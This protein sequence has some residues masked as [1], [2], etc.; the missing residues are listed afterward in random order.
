MRGWGGGREGREPREEEGEGR[1]RRGARRPW[2]VFYPH[3]HRFPPPFTKPRAETER[4]REKLWIFRT[5]HFE[6]PQMEQ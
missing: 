5:V 2:G 3:P 6:F 1:W 4:E